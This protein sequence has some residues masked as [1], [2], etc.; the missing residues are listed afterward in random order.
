M[1]ID[2]LSWLTSKPY[3]EVSYGK[4]ERFLNQSLIK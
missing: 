2:V 3:G 1:G 4:P